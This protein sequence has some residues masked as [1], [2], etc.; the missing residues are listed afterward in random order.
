MSPLPEPPR[1]S[2]VVLALQECVGLSTDPPFL[3]SAL[4][5]SPML[6]LCILNMISTPELHRYFNSRTL[7]GTSMIAVSLLLLIKAWTLTMA[8]HRTNQS[9]LTRV[10]DG[11]DLDDVTHG[12]E[13][14]S[15]IR[16]SMCLLFIGLVFETVSSVWALMQSVSS[17]A[18]VTP[19]CGQL[20]TLTYFSDRMV[21]HCTEYDEVPEIIG[22]NGTAAIVSSSNHTSCSLDDIP[23]GELCDCAWWDNYAL[24][25]NDSDS[26]AWTAANLS[27]GEGEGLCVVTSLYKL[28]NDTDYILSREK[29]ANALENLNCFPVHPLGFKVASIMLVVAVFGAIVGEAFLGLKYRVDGISIALTRWTAVSSAVEAAAFITAIVF[30]LD[31][32]GDDGYSDVAGEVSGNRFRMLG[33]AGYSA[34]ALVG[35]GAG[36]VIESSCKT[37][38]PTAN[39]LYWSAFGSMAIW[40]GAALGE[41]VITAYVVWRQPQ[42]AARETWGVLGSELIGLIV[43]EVVGVA[44]V[45]AA[46]VVLTK[47]ELS[48]LSSKVAAPANPI[49]LERPVSRRSLA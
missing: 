47:V 19:D 20:A 17:G 13:R 31:W 25:I 44:L 22:W 10:P 48:L 3:S 14:E 35:F 33:W 7:V 46:R 4:A 28:V 38:N 45:W 9:A 26:C 41:L 42:N 15:S 23:G 16:R 11:V 29:F 5:F 49:E 32:D 1:D 37:S 6:L 12:K 24:N 18:F 30:V 2:C 8:P 40:L 36:A 43:A 21:Q 39:R 27:R 34:C